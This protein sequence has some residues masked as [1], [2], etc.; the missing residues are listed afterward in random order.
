MGAACFVNNHVP[1][2]FTDGLLRAVISGMWHFYCGAGS[3]LADIDPLQRG[4]SG[5]GPNAWI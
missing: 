5:S 2:D 1:H 4:I 3:M